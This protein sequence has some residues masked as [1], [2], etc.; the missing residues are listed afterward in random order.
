MSV[1]EKVRAYHEVHGDDFGSEGSRAARYRAI[2]QLL[3][4][5]PGKTLLDVG[6]G[7]RRFRRMLPRT[8]E[9]TGIDLLYGQNV[10]DWD[11]PADV[12]VAGGIVYK[13]RDEREARRVLGH[14]WELTREAFVWTSLDKWAHF[15]VDELTLDP[16]DSARWA[17]KLAGSGKVA[18]RMDYKP[19]DFAILMLR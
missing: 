19:G 4:P 9:Y 5:L 7:E 12:V 3:P 15:H 6:C 13:L 17:R 8:C 10:L 14:C 16:Y 2:K 11:T 18:L 1:Y